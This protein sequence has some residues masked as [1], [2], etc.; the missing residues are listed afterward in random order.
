M[1]KKGLDHHLASSSCVLSLFFF[2]L[3]RQHFLFKLQ[4]PPQPPLSFDTDSTVH[5]SA[6]EG[7]NELSVGVGGGG[8]TV[9]Y[10]TG[11]GAVRLL[12]EW[13]WQLA[14]VIGCK[15]GDD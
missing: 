2:L 4:S 9:S 7:M 3:L 1:T 8:L 14:D 15:E 13:T 5:C 11:D 6:A 10:S 12:Y